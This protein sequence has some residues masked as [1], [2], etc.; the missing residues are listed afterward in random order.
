METREKL[1]V[2]LMEEIGEL[3]EVLLDQ[4]VVDDFE[5]GCDLPEGFCREASD[6]LAA[7]DVIDDLYGETG[8]DQSENHPEWVEKVKLHPRPIRE[9]LF[10]L[11]KASSKLVRFGRGE[12]KTK[13]VPDLAIWD[14]WAAEV[15]NRL[16]GGVHDEQYQRKLA[17]FRGPTEKFWA[18]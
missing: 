11:H 4:G 7:I 8:S 15:W 13:G 17:L 3:L 16:H 6:V 1:L 2:I 9:T 10:A 14:F 18:D 12:S 5:E